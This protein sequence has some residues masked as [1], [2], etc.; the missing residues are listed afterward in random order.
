MARGGGGAPPQPDSLGD[1]GGGVLRFEP[2]P[3]AADAQPP[4]PWWT[5]P[6]LAAAV[7]RGQGWRAQRERGRRPARGLAALRCIPLPA[8]ALAPP[9]PASLPAKQVLSVSSAGAVFQKLPDVPP[10]TLAAWRLQLTTLI[11]AAGAVPQWRA[12]PA[13]D[14]ARAL[15]APDALWTAFSG[16]CLAVHFGAWVA[17]LKATSLPH[18]LLLV[19]MAPVLLV[20]LALARRQPIS[21]GEVAGTLLALTGE[22]GASW[23][24]GARLQLAALARPWRPVMHARDAHSAPRSA[25]LQAPA[26]SQR[27][28]RRA[29]RAPR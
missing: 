29:R 14:R 25:Q 16:S 9:A 12:M 11:L 19:S 21:G 1:G 22:A 13:P 27:A 17:S 2:E 24:P 5:L 15:A 3:A 7:R 26:S 4:R 8:P 6:L 20:L 23:V 28:R 18:S 10:V